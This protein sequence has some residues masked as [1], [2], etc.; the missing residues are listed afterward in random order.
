MPTP[1]YL[2]QESLKT[3]LITATAASS[4]IS[5]FVIGVLGNLP[6]A[7]APGIGGAAPPP[8]RSCT[9]Q[10]PSDRPSSCTGHTVLCCAVLC[11]AVPWR[12]RSSLR[13]LLV[14]VCMRQGLGGGRCP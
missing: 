6:L 14:W 13:A 10:A 4:L 1:D 3:N 2:M 8:P 7:L 12:Y 5:T 11:R 9:M